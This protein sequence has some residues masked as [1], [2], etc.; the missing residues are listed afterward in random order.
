MLIMFNNTP[1]AALLLAVARLYSCRG[2]QGDYSAGSRYKKLKAYAD[3]IKAINTHEH[4]RWISAEIPASIATFFPGLDNF[5][6][7]K[8]PA[9]PLLM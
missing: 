8:I 2:I 6:I 9:S 4:Q 5:L 3:E 1:M 7:Y